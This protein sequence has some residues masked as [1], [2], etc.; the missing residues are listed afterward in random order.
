M[1]A[2]EA[3]TEFVLAR[4]AEDESIAQGVIDAAARLYS[5]AELDKYLWDADVESDAGFVAI[6]AGR[7]LRECA[8]KRVAV[9]YYLNDDDTI[10]AATV[11]A[12]AAIYADHP[13]Y[14]SEWAA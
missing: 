11:T 7:I 13:D 8:A 9:D 6:G 5:G 14:R 3:L 12:M 4:V 2:N 10:M 1:T